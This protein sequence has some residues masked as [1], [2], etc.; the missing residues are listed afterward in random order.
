[1]LKKIRHGLLIGA[2]GFVV[3]GIS[4]LLKNLFLIDRPLAFFRKNNLIETINLVAGVDVHT[5]A[6]SF[7]SGHAMSAFA[8]YSLLILYLPNKARYVIPLFGIA[9]CVA[10]SRVYLVQHFFPDVYAGSIIGVALALLFYSI[11]QRWI[12]SEDH[13]MEKPLWRKKA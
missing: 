4:F 11:D 2:I 5:G 3:M 6:T 1:M 10:I 12:L 9:V 13:F 8:L 7:P